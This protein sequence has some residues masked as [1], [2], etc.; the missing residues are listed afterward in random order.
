[1]IV[2]STSKV[3]VCEEQGAIFHVTAI[4][5]TVIYFARVFTL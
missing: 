3:I 5:V 1:M 4:C 2:N